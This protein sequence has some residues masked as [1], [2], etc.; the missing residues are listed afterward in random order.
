MI[1]SVV[2]FRTYSTRD[3]WMLTSH[4]QSVVL[5]AGELNINLLINLFIT[6]TVQKAL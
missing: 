4:V 2:T 5:H 6:V 1:S 3:F